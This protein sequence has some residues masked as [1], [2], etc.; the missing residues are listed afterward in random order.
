MSLNDGGK[1]DGIDDKQN[2]SVV[3][4]TVTVVVKIIVMIISLQHL[5]MRNMLSMRPDSHAQTSNLAV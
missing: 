3:V 4:A 1:G 5:S 2:W